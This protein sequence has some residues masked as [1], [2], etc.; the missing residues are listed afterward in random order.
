MS[1]TVKRYRSYRRDLDEVPAG[2]TRVEFYNYHPIGFSDQLVLVGNLEV[3]GLWV[4]C[5]C[6][7]FYEL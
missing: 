7:I 3:F 5:I 4:Y 2:S 1:L 6:F